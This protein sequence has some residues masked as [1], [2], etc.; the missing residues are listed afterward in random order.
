MPFSRLAVSGPDSAISAPVTVSLP[1]VAALIQEIS[2]S[3]IPSTP[4]ASATPTAASATAQTGTA[5]VLTAPNIAITNRFDSTAH[6]LADLPAK[7]LSYTI[8][9]ACC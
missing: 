8:A 1:G 7:P 2:I 3:A 5:P 6:W 9:G 4:V